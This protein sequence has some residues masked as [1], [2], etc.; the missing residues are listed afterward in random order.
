MSASLKDK[1]NQQQSDKG[2]EFSSSVLQ[3][4]KSFTNVNILLRK[5]NAYLNF[6]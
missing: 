2:R 4:Y 3:K 1:S 5:K 6:L